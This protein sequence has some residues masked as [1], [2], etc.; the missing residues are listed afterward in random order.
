M[1]QTLFSVQT[2]A[3]E[4]A[5]RHFAL[6]FAAIGSDTGM[7]YAIFGTATCRAVAI[8]LA[9]CYAMCLLEEVESAISLQTCY[10]VPGIDLAYAATRATSL[11]ETRSQI[12]RRSDQEFVSGVPTYHYLPTYL[13]TY[14]PACLPACLPASLSISIY[15]SSLLATCRS[16]YC[17]RALGTCTHIS[18]MHCALSVYVV[19]HLM[20]IFSV[21]FLRYIRHGRALCCY[22]ASFGLD[23][24]ERQEGH[25]RGREE[26]ERG[27]ARM[28][29]KVVTGAA[30]GLDQVGTGA[31][32]VGTG[33][34][35]MVTGAAFGSDDVDQNLGER[36]GKR[37]PPEMVPIPGQSCAFRFDVCD[38]M[39]CDV[40]RCGA[41][42]GIALV[43]SWLWRLLHGCAWR[44]R[45]DAMR[46]DA[47]RCDV[48]S[49]DGFSV[50]MAGVA[51]AWM[52]VACCA[53]RMRGPAVAHLSYLLS[54]SLRD[55]RY[56]AT[57]CRWFSAYARAVRCGMLCYIAVLYAVRGT[58]IA[59]CAM[60]GAGMAGA[61]L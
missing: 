43:L 10:A 15:L 19:L 36:G 32:E 25:S 27:R 33:A 53:W 34:G 4:P 52:R 44:V 1:P 61:V 8:T 9:V 29:Q 57:A 22:Q 20:C 26:H 50:E 38:V 7:W 41:I 35:E 6:D 59:S 54:S 46:C 42:V 16:S 60:C 49:C 18:V 11:R 13:P 23:E 2:A 55:M 40:M 14:L 5:V 12:A 28:E 56:T 47:I 58:D 39:R 17:A 45:C 37:L 30:F 3:F 48:R 51:G 21:L 24:G 31:D